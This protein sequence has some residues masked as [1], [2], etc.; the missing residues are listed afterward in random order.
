MAIVLNTLL[1]PTGTQPTLIILR[2]NQ[3]TIENYQIKHQG[4]KTLNIRLEYSYHY[5][6]TVVNY[7]STDLIYRQLNLLLLNYN[8]PNEEDFWE[9]MN[10]YL[11]DR[12]LRLNPMLSEVTIAIAVHPNSEFPYHRS[13]TVNQTKSG[14]RYE[15]WHFNFPLSFINPIA[16]H[17]SN[18]YQV[19]V[20]YVYDTNSSEFPYPD[21]IIIY[22]QL[23]KLLL[24]GNWKPK[25]W[26]KIQH[27]L[28]NSLLRKNST[29]RSL[30]VELEQLVRLM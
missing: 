25:S 13:T 15:T 28:K 11:T 20:D 3:L 27:N 24:A 5:E 6:L 7:L 1:S 4:T 30:S 2:K 9:V 18:S 12:I 22:E 23:K 14:C 16:K 29:L 26:I 8:Y 19:N 10:C 21:F 17:L